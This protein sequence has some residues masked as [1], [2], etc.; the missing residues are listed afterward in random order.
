MDS[1]KK[2]IAYT[3]VLLFLEQVE[4]AMK[5]NDRKTL[6]EAY[7]AMKYYVVEHWDMFSSEVKAQLDML[8]KE[9]RK[10]FEKEG[11]HVYG[12]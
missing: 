7:V 8:D 3:K 1:V 5:R 2:R 10:M 11:E 4:D 12:D 6:S 9:F